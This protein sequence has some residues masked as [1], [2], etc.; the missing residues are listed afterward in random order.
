MALE[1][2]AMD[3]VMKHGFTPFITPDVAKEE[4]L[5]GIGFNPRGAESNIYTIEG[6]DT[7]L[8][9]TAEITLGGYYRRLHEMQS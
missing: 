7:C 5:N 3:I 4:I 6:T 2:Y 8:V 1:R 9:G